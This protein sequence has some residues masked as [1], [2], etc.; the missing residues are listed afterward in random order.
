MEEIAKCCFELRDVDGNW[1]KHVQWF[2]VHEIGYEMLLGRRFCKDNGFTSLDEKLSAWSPTADVSINGLCAPD[3]PLQ[4]NPT[5]L[6]LL[7][8]RAQAP[9]GRARFKRAP[10]CVVGDP[11][12]AVVNSI[13]V[14]TLKASN[15]LSDLLVLDSFTFDE[16]SYVLLEFS[17]KCS[18]HAASVNTFREWFLVCVDHEP[19]CVMLRSDFLSQSNIA[20]HVVFVKKRSA[21]AVESPSP[22]LQPAVVVD[23]EK[24]RQEIKKRAEK[25]RI[26]NEHRFT[27]HH[28]VSL[29][30]QCCRL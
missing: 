15:P 16:D 21:V 2:G 25:D 5:C 11:S 30:D 6:Q 19:G 20:D 26:N 13:A 3:D 10:K 14:A 27:S 8:T 7:F 9:L 1:R 23:P 24:R 17:V 29:F 18:S 28:P 4:H 22:P 12:S